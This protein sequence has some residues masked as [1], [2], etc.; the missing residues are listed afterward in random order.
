MV[1]QSWPHSQHQLLLF[2]G[3]WVHGC[4]RDH[5]IASSFPI[6]PSTEHIAPSSTPFWGIGMWLEGMR[7]GLEQ[8]LQTIQHD[9]ETELGCGCFS[10]CARQALPHPTHPVGPSE[11]DPA[12]PRFWLSHRHRWNAQLQRA[13]TRGPGAKSGPQTWR[14]WP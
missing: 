14:V 5:Y 6:C 3:G 1:H 12:S 2:T 10:H 7:S 11:W 13:Q 4:P 8:L 9:K